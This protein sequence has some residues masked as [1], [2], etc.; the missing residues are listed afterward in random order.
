MGIKLA[1][2][3]KKTIQKCYEFTSTLGALNILNKNRANVSGR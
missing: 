1:E 2:S 3:Q